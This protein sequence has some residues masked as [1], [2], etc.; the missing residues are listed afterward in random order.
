MADDADFAA[1]HLARQEADFAKRLRETRTAPSSRQRSRC[2]D[3]DAPI[4]PPNEG[5]CLDCQDDIDR[6]K[7]NRRF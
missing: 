3:C 5:R 1:E 2:L 6:I 4:E 7:A